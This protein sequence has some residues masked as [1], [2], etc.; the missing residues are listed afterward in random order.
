MVPLNNICFQPFSQENVR[1]CIAHWITMSDIPFS[2]IENPFF[3][4]M[5]LCASDN[6]YKPVL[7]RSTVRDDIEKIHVFF[8]KLVKG[9]SSVYNKFII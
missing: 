4:Q 2:E 1:R 3:K 9:S 6:Q 7:S 5:M 8:K